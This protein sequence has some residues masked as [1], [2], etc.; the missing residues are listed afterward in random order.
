MGKM[1]KPT[2]FISYSH[3]DEI[4]KERLITHLAVLQQGLLKVWNDRRIQAGDEWYE[5]IQS[6][7]AAAT[8][9]QF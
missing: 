4:W 5:E 7:I 9:L 8:A 1:N 2:V 6:A 3:R